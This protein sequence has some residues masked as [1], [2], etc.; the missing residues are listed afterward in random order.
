LTYYILIMRSLYSIFRNG[1]NSNFRINATNTTNQPR[2][3]NLELYGCTCIRKAGVCLPEH[4]AAH[5]GQ[6]KMSC[7]TSADVRLLGDKLELDTQQLT[8]VRTPPVFL[9]HVMRYT[10]Q[11]SKCG[12]SMMCLL[13]L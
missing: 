8:D 4:T 6:R 11:N 2:F 10:K 9:V 13:T 5:P 1:T 7:L 3:F 12:D